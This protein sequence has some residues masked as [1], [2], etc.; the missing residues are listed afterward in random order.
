MS[1]IGFADNIRE[2]ISGSGTTITLGGAV[3][4]FRAISSVCADGDTIYLAARKGS[5]FSFGKFTYHTGGTITQTTVVYST[6]GNN[7]V[8]FS[9]GTGEIISDVPAALLLALAYMAYAASVVSVGPNR[10]TN[11]TLKLDFAAAS[12]ATGLK[13]TAAAAA[14][15]VA[16][17]A[18]SSG[19]NEDFKIDALGTGKVRIGVTSTGNIE[20]LRPVVQ[21]NMPSFL[22][23]NSADD[24]NITGAG[25]TVT[26]D[27]DTEIFD[28][29]GNFS[30][31]TYTAPVS[32]NHAFIGSVQLGG[33]AAANIIDLRVITSNR[34]YAAYY[35][36]GGEQ[37]SGFQ[38]FPFN[39]FADMDA[40]DTAIVQVSV[41][42]GTTIVDVTG[43]NASLLITFFGGFL[44]G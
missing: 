43:G 18:I 3:D 13:V 23:Y 35:M 26:I 9:S 19:S 5:E 15:G 11:P 28:R 33:L 42:G 8:S 21:A 41:F 25:E 1:D 17:A 16:L 4:T 31:D 29:A 40:G 37:D 6:N 12:A 2:T 10:A 36:K 14:A 7:A 34:S 39:V 32:G 44:V 27:F 38:R 22:A 20:L 30:A 24:L